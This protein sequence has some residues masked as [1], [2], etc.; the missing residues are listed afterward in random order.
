M[1]KFIFIAI[2]LFATGIF[3]YTNGNFSYNSTIASGYWTEA[4]ATINNVAKNLFSK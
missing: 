1:K 4:V 3:T 2:F